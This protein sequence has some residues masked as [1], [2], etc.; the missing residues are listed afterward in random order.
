M[1]KKSFLKK[2]SPR[3]NFDTGT[4]PPVKLSIKVEGSVPRDQ[5]PQAVPKGYEWFLKKLRRTRYKYVTRKVAH[6][7][8]EFKY[9]GVKYDNIGEHKVYGYMYR[10]R[11]GRRRRYY[12]IRRRY[13]Y[14]VYEPV[15]KKK[16]YHTV[17]PW[18]VLRE[19][20]KLEITEKWVDA[21]EWLQ[22]KCTEFGV[23][24]G[25]L[26]QEQTLPFDNI[27]TSLQYCWYW[28]KMPQPRTWDL[29]F[30]YYIISLY[31]LKSNRKILVSSSFDLG[32]DYTLSQI[33][34]DM[35]PAAIKT[36]RERINR[37]S[38]KGMEISFV[39]YVAFS[40]VTKRELN[41]GR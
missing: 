26:E 35:L 6:T 5:L 3:K 17:E 2:N 34:T 18:W 30:I 41:E 13:A 12:I 29:I 23:D 14:K 31:K 20:K 24:Y 11:A 33:M 21:T 38:E 1:N 19:K 4:N 37:A 32:G 36:T 40:A 16:P 8:Y 15:R 7:Y 28:Q 27:E 22:H 9:V 10:K 39:G 25:E